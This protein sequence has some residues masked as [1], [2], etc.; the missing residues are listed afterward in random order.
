MLVRIVVEELANLPKYLF[1]LFSKYIS[2]PQLSYDMMLKVT[3]VEIELL[4]DIDQILFIEQNIRGGVSFINT[5]YCKAEKITSK[6]E[7]ETFFLETIDI[8]CKFLIST[9]FIM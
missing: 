1:L 8:D 4:T 5:R 6:D 3:K 9:H 2:T 7:T